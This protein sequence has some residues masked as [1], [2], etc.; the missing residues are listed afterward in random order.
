MRILIAEDDL[1]SRIALAGIL[2]KA[3]YDVVATCMSEPELS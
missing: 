3:G 2:K 1:T